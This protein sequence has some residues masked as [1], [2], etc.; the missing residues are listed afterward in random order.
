LIQVATLGFREIDEDTE[1][2]SARARKHGDAAVLSGSRWIF[3]AGKGLEQQRCCGKVS[4]VLDDL[5]E[6]AIHEP[7]S[8]SASQTQATIAKYGSSS[9]QDVDKV[10]F[11]VLQVKAVALILVKTVLS[12]LKTISP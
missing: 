7:C 8:P 9:L 6:K 10:I 2:W 4:S 3:L 12:Q 11:W 1:V 5:A